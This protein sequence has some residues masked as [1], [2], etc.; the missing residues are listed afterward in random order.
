[1]GW[2]VKGRAIKKKRTTFFSNVPMFQRPLSSRGGG[3]R[4]CGFPYYV[5]IMLWFSNI[6]IFE[7][8]LF[9]YSLLY[10]TLPKFS[11]QM[12]WISVRFYEMGDIETLI[13][14]VE[15][16]QMVKAQVWYTRRLGSPMEKKAKNI[17]LSLT[18]LYIFLI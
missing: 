3:V 18:N 14:G 1:M 8:W 4:P 9:I 2:G 16:A 6:I 17:S 7:Q 5:Y 13:L 11:L 10:T 12:H 15:M